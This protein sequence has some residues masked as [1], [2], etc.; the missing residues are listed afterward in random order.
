[1]TKDSE[2]RKI[3][4]LGNEWTIEIDYEEG[5]VWGIGVWDESTQSYV[6]KVSE[7]Y[8]LEVIGKNLLSI[9]K[10]LNNLSGEEN[11]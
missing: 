8:E 2:V 1:M 9:G 7:P 3:K 11:E 5:K 10:E 4:V 6:A